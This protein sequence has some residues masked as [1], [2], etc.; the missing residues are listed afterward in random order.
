MKTPLKCL[1]STVVSVVLCY[2]LLLAAP[3]SSDIPIVDNNRNSVK[4][5]VTDPGGP[6]AVKRTLSTSSS[7]LPN[8]GPGS[9]ASVSRAELTSNFVPLDKRSSTDAL[10]TINDHVEVSGLQLGISVPAPAH[11]FDAHLATLLGRTR[12]SAILSGATRV[13]VDLVAVRSWLFKAAPAWYIANYT[14]LRDSDQAVIVLRRR[15]EMFV[16]CIAGG[17][18]GRANFVEWTWGQRTPIQW[19]ADEWTPSL[20]PIVDLHPLYLKDRF[21][22]LTFKISR[23]WQRVFSDFGASSY[24]WYVRL[25]DDNYFHEEFTYSALGRLSS[26]AKLMAGKI[27]W[28]NMG[29]N[30]VFPFAG[31]GA[32]WF[33]SKGGLEAVGPTI[34][35]AEDWFFKFRARKDIFLPHHIHD[36]DVFLTAW[37]HL[38]NISFVNIPGV[39]HVSPGLKQKQRCLRDEQLFKLRW[40]PNETIYF[41]YPAREAQFRIEEA[42]YAYSKPIVWH[43]MSPTRL[44]KLEQ[45]LYPERAAFLGSLKPPPTAADI[46]KPRRQCY[47]GVPDGPSPPRGLSIF[48][49]PLAEKETWMFQPD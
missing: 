12:L 7:T 16:F 2:I 13:D 40:E 27:G 15:V 9:R 31:G 32:G 5:F 44:V 4:Q 14:W 17:S 30:A 48:E 36:E 3:P 37:F 19:Y 6:P 24:D 8:G 23:I 38:Q 20:R 33:L 29:P 26:D 47:P 18:D 25:W 11:S 22:L 21:G 41:D 49:R 46:A 1:L 45:V 34:L 28:R 35:Q 42:W 10:P 43:Y 39:E